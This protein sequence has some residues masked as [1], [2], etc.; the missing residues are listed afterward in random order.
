MSGIEEFVSTPNITFMLLMFSV[1]GFTFEL[2]NPGGMLPGI[3]G[4]VTFLLALLGI[5][6]LPIDLVWLAIMSFG[7]IL[8]GIEGYIRKWG[9]L[10]VIGGAIFAYGATQV[11][12]LKSNY[13]IGIDMWIIIL[14]T[15]LTEAIIY[16]TT[17]MFKHSKERPIAVGAE[18]IKGSKAEIINWHETSG[19][20]ASSGSRWSAKS[21]SSQKFKSGDEVIVADIDGLKLIVEPLPPKKED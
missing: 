8:I 16:T 17:Y 6:N 13:G 19:E 1:Y 4:I 9:I 3:I 21:K 18:A 14:M 20:V 2:F 11:I 12:V 15:L 10:A 5:K 7:V